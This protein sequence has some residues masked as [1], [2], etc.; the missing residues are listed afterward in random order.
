MSE[1]PRQAIRAFVALDL[2]PTSVR[3]IARIADRLRMGSGAPSATWTPVTRMHVTLKFMA[4]LPVDLVAP[5]GSAMRPLV[6]GKTA[7]RPSP[8]RLDAFPT[9]EHARIIVAELEDQS[10]RLA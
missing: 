6:E 7:P 9:V 10:A 3:R 5:L 1:N 2:D 8:V 4:A